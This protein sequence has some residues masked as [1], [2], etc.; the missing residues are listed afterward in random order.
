MDNCVLKWCYATSTI[1]VRGSGERGLMLLPP[2]LRVHNAVHFNR[3]ARGS[4]PNGP[5][6]G[7]PSCQNIRL[8]RQ[9]RNHA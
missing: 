6:P 2:I 9:Y 1:E 7:V 3:A 8:L 5:Q 4:P